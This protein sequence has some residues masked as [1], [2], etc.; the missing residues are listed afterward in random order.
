MGQSQKKYLSSVINSN[1]D[2]VEK[3]LIARK[4]VHSKVAGGKLGETHVKP[5]MSCRTI[6]FLDPTAPSGF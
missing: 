2:F 5:V 4:F 1:P 3:L 6:R